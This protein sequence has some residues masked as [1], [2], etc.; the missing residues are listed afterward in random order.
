MIN[1]IFEWL[2]NIL[3]QNIYMAVTASF[4]WGL[5]SVL[6]SPCH[7]SSLPLVIG[8]INRNGVTTVKTAFYNSL[9]FAAGILITIALIG[10]ITGLL[11]G[12]IGDI[13]TVGNYMVAIVFFAAGLYLLGVINPDWNFIHPEKVHSKGYLLAF[14]LGLLFGAGLGPCTFAFMAPVLGVVFQ[15]SAEHFAYAI[16]LIAAFAVGHALVIAAAGTMS[17]KIGKYLNWA[18]SSRAVLIFKKACGVLVILGG[19]HFIYTTF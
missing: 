6:L 12:L 8:Y 5:L 1:G 2:N 11:G 9:M 13:G 10:L 16:L 4:L 14:L 18:D 15:Y 17:A 19:V 7:L 3:T